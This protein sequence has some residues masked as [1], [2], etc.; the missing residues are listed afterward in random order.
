MSKR[1]CTNINEYFLSR[2][3]QNTSNTN[4]NLEQ[5]DNPELFDFLQVTGRD[6]EQTIT[7]LNRTAAVGKD[8]ISVK[9]LNRTKSFITP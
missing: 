4:A 2:A 5:N 9:F 1:K 8:G 3:S 6:V 7:K